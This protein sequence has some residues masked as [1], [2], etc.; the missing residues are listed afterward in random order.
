[1]IQ[2]IVNFFWMLFQPILKIL[3]L[4]AL[5]RTAIIASKVILTGFFVTAYLSFLNILT[6]LYDLID[7][8]INFSTTSDGTS[9]TL[10]IFW[11]MLDTLGVIDFVNSILPALLSTFGALSLMLIQASIFRAYKLIDKNIKDVAKK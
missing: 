11:H 2:F 4:D 9:C 5:S 6:L 7:K 10:I 1:M 3:G 8:L